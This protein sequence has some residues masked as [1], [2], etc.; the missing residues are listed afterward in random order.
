MSTES[1][2]KENLSEEEIDQAVVA[3]ADDDAAWEKPI[4]V[5]S[6]NLIPTCTP[7]PGLLADRT[8][9]QVR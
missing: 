7:A 9:R 3:Q 8:Q 5:H 1:K 4:Y 2:M 6:T